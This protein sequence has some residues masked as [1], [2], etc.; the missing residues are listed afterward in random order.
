[1]ARGYGGDVSS[2]KRPARSDRRRQREEPEA[3]RRCAPCRRVPDGRGGER[4]RGDRA[5]DRA[6]AGRDP[7]GPASSPTWRARTSRASSRDGARTARI[8]VVALSARR[9]ERRSRSAARG[10]VR[11]LPREAD[12]RRRVPGPGP[13]LLEDRHAASRVCQHPLE[14]PAGT[15]GTRAHASSTVAELTLDGCRSACEHQSRAASSGEPGGRREVR[16]CGHC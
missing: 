4:R 11:R 5:R 15:V 14:R 16:Q 6:A 7:D 1:M 8:P 12:R 2:S 9:Y 3:R 13:E 10:W